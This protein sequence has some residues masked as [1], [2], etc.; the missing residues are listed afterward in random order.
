[1]CGIALQFAPG[2]KARAL[3]LLRLRHRGPDAQ[4]EW[5]SPDG[6]CW[7]GHTRLAILDLSAN[8]AQPMLDPETGNAITY[9]GE[10]YNHRALRGRLPE[11]NGQ[12]RG[13]SDTETILAGYGRWGRAMPARLKGMFA[14]AIYDARKKS[15]FVCRDRFGMKPVYYVWRDGVLSLA[16]EVRALL[17]IA[18]PQYSSASIAA[19]LGTGACPDEH[20]LW[21]AIQCLPPGFTLEVT[22][23][24]TLNIESFREV[25]R[26]ASV[27]HA[28]PVS[29]VR[30]LLEYSVEDH[31]QSDVPVA[32]FLSGGV[33][34]SIITA[35]A[36]QKLSQPLLTFS[37]GYPQRSFDETAVAAEVAKR[38]RTDHHRIELNEEETVALVRE[39]VTR[40]DLPSVDAINT[41]IVASVVAAR[42]VKVA[43]T[44]LGGDELFGGYPV[45]R[46]IGRLRWLARC[47]ASLR[48][49][50]ARLGQWGRR[51]AEMPGDDLAAIVRWRRR[52]MTGSE[53]VAAG[54]PP[55][56]FKVDDSP[57]RLPDDFARVSWSEMTGYMRNM[58]LRDSDQM[59][60][61]VSLEL[62]APFLD[63]ELVEYLFHL[64]AREKLRHGGSKGLLVAACR[65]LLPASVYRRPRMGFGPPMHEWMRGP[66]ESFTEEGVAQVRARE[67]MKPDYLARLLDGFRSGTIHWTRVWSVAVLG[68]Y[69][70]NVR[71]SFEKEARSP[72]PTGVEKNCDEPWCQVHFA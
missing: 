25:P 6:A 70:E 32:S 58:L 62:R 53:A 29:R 51:V 40:L 45:F 49:L 50:L 23:V 28:D 59:S 69:L 15:I 37:V 65:D 19:Y 54:L 42:G 21:P 71:V 34:S 17:G 60:M 48:P 52:F 43:L 36:A 11:R 27:S 35:L 5:R 41:Y 26:P 38:Y 14:F 55:H 46:E 13:D 8:G 4:G 30:E 33:D 72:R 1:M 9:N 68:H 22:P 18:S 24:G 31:L 7:F 61:A 44:G 64:P 3:P 57:A 47:P 56:P 16:S 63:H 66:Q 10:I 12:W 67:I 39:A 20:L 2:R